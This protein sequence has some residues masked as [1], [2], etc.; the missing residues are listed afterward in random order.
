[1]IMI[2]WI[3]QDAHFAATQERMTVDS[4]EFPVGDSMVGCKDVSNFAVLVRFIIGLLLLL[5]TSTTSLS[6][7][8]V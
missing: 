4:R 3:P 8:S 2:S 6:T 7:S 1:M 5:A